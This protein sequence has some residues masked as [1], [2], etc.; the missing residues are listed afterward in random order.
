MDYSRIGGC[1]ERFVSPCT[2]RPLVASV[3]N[4]IM[5]AKVEHYGLLEGFLRQDMYNN[6]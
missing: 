2:A 4:Y 5:S 1:F 3:A 6:Y